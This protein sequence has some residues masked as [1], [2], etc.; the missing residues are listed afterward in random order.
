MDLVRSCPICRG[1]EFEFQFKAN[2]LSIVRCP[3]CRLMFSDPQPDD[4]ALSAIYSN[5]YFLTGPEG[6]AVSG[7]RSMKR[8]TARLY[9]DQ[10]AAYLGNSR[11]KLLEIGCGTGEFLVEAKGKGFEVAGM[12]L[13]SHACASANLLL[14][15][16][17]VKLGGPDDLAFADGEFDVCVLFDV[18]EHVRDPVVFLEKLRR[19]L[20]PGGT[21]F[22][23]T[24]DLDSWSAR[25]MGQR[26]MEFKAEHLFYFGRQ[27]IQA[28]LAKAG[29]DGVDL[30]PN[31]KILTLDYVHR[32]FKRFPV[33]FFS[34]LVSW[35]HALV[36]KVLRERE[37][38]VVAS[39]MRVFAR[40]AAP[41]PRPVL[42]IVV[43]VY[44]E[45]A[46][47]GQLLEALIQKPLSGVD[48][49]IIVVESRSTDG[50]RDIVE[51]FRGRPGVTI[52]HEEAPR[53]KGHAVRTGFSHA[54]GDLVLIQDGDLEYDLNDYDQLLEPLL[55]FEAAFVLGSRHSGSWKIR[56]FAQ[57]PT[58]AL[59]MNLGHLFFTALLNLSL[60]TRL[61]DP[62]TMYK[63]FR[64]DCLEG[65]EFKADRFDFDWELVIKLVRKGYKPLEIP[66]NY[67]SRSFKE[68][69]KVTLVKDPLLWIWALL[70]FRLG[71]LFSKKKAA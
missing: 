7:Y 52:V 15:P 17:T 35:V 28:A 19:T 66:V 58:I 5:D 26:W 69:K 33:P 29:F 10:L 57:E 42:S 23:C 6:S 64:R 3:R 30:A 51:G 27:T 71:P 36:P 13:S 46:T 68:G 21:L 8:A 16:D 22:V 32:H 37:V 45:A 55:R 47:A 48:K 40:A 1:G 61:K 63:V 65:L 41:R 67:R 25:L 18:L 11:G 38:K 2:G 31:H 39:G 53:G 24:P 34:R 62:F 60:G 4:Q 44:N 20:K 9:L 70:R 59:G 54:S 50:T 14:G 43:P 56:Q 49:E 12:D